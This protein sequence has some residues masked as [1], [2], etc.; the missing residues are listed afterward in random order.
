[1]FDKEIWNATFLFLIEIP[2]VWVLDDMSNSFLGGSVGVCVVRLQIRISLDFDW[3]LIV[4]LCGYS[5]IVF[6]VKYLL[7][8]DDVDRVRHNH[9]IG[10]S[11]Q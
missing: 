9:N 4:V 2:H 7:A 8:E 3:L 5:G 10:F 6:N 1:M 11:I